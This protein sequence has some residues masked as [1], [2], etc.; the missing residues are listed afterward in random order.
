M[1]LSTQNY[2]SE[3]EMT[4][5]M[6]VSTAEL[7]EII[8][9]RKEIFN[10]FYPTVVEG[11]RRNDRILMDGIARYRDRNVEILSSAYLLNYTVFDVKG[12]DGSIVWRATGV[13]KREVDKELST[14]TKY[15][16]EQCKV[17]GYK[18]PSSLFVNMTALRTILTLCMRFY[19][20]RGDKDRLKAV[21][22]YMAY[23]MFHTCFYNSF[24][25]PPRKAT[26]VYTVNTMSNKHKL[27]QLGSVDALLTYG[28]ELCA[29]T[30]RQRILDCRDSDLIYVIQQF[31]SRQRGYIKDIA[32]KYFEN[33]NKKEAIFESKDRLTSSDEDDPN[34]VERDSMAGEIEQLSQTY[35]TRFFQKPLDDSIISIIS[36]MNEISRVEVKNAL[37]S[38]RSDTGRITEV[39]SF[40]EAIFFL[41]ASGEGRSTVDVHTK[42]FLSAMDAIYR[43]GNSKDKNI[44]VV[45]SS[46]DKWLTAFSPVYREATRLA[47]LNNYRKAIFQYFIFAVALRH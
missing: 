32:T 2:Y 11:L 38:L 18:P 25:T 37:T 47:K 14:L 36:R 34:F 4:P 24:R 45:K 23:S 5:A 12:E 10:K 30:Y 43:K 7:V 15:I 6:E 3:P 13:N 31:K 9:S 33:Y 27:K 44:I 8:G 28:V 19:I 41:Y 46:L 39:R 21:C 35:T 42:K 1:Q 20:E 17:R 29:T 26:M 40:Y 22:A 16:A